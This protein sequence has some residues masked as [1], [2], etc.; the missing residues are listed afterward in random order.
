MPLD[1]PNHLYT[2]LRPYFVS[3]ERETVL[4]AMVDRQMAERSISAAQA[5]WDIL[6]IIDTKAGA[7]LTHISL[8]TAIVGIMLV[9]FVESRLEQGILLLEMIAYLILGVMCLQCFRLGQ[10][11]GSDLEEEIVIEG[12]MHEIAFR[13]DL[14]RFCLNTTT[15]VTLFF[16]ATMVLHVFLGPLFGP[17]PD[18]PSS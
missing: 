14:H 9:S 6:D 18:T 1:V 13:W 5:Q 8:M 17:S 3:E 2:F 12:R 10:G 16:I 4:Q 11:R 15:L 7:L